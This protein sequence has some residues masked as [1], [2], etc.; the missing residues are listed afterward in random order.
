MSDV[1]II[2]DSK[3]LEQMRR[4]RWGLHVLLAISVAASILVPILCATWSYQHIDHFSGMW[5]PNNQ[6]PDGLR[7]VLIT[8]GGI[9]FGGAI[10]IAILRSFFAPVERRLS[11]VFRE[12][13]DYAAAY[14][15]YGR[16]VTIFATNRLHRRC[17]QRW[18]FANIVH[19]EHLCRQLGADYALRRRKSGTA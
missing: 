2:S 8:G 1:S 4:R 18:G 6:L 5:D 11:F 17:E 14:G 19:D 16:G 9:C 10:G 13:D 15:V 12:T 7:A 3:L